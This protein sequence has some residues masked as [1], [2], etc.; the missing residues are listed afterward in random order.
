MGAG[1]RRGRVE[2][3]RVKEI[4]CEEKDGEEEDV[5]GEGGR[6]ERE[7][8]EEGEEGVGNGI[9]EGQGKLCEKGRVEAVCN[10]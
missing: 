8:K 10:M 7:E 4:N 5:G 2:S 6:G 9:S 3:G 1:R